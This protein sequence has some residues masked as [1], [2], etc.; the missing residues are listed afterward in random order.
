MVGSFVSTKPMVCID[1]DQSRIVIASQCVFNVVG[2]SNLIVNDTVQI[3]KLNDAKQVIRWSAIYDPNDK[4]LADV[5]TQ[6]T[7]KL[8]KELSK[9]KENPTP[10]TVEE[11]QAFAK[12]FLDAAAAGFAKNNHADAFTKIFADKLS[13]DWSDGTKVSETPVFRTPIFCICT[14]PCTSFV[15]NCDNIIQ[16]EGPYAD[17][18]EISHKNWSSMVTDF[19]Y[20]EPIVAVDTNRSIV[21]FA[22]SI[23]LNVT[24]RLS[25]ETNPVMMNQAFCMHL[26]ED[27]K[28]HKW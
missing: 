1:T 9:P 23:V 28:S 18:M 8:G 12:D 16:G 20:A 13:W 14:L 21:A 26:N 19:L 4:Q 27:K 17:I 5:A 15:S 24:G 11:G 22:T 25:D 2:A 10:L 3:L 7:K 6:V